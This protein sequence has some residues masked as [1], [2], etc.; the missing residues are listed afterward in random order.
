M[1]VSADDYS[2]RWDNEIYL[3]DYVEGFGLQL[4]LGKE[5]WVGP[6]VSLGIDISYTLVVQEDTV[7][8]SRNWLSNSLMFRFTFSRS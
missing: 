7:D 1:G 2:L 4:E 5:W 6:N 8:D 3:N